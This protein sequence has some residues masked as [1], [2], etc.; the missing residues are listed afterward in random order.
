[1]ENG[2][3]KMPNG[4]TDDG[5]HLVFPFTIFHLPFSIGNHPLSAEV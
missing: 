2:K 3:W 1:M 5:A 4:K